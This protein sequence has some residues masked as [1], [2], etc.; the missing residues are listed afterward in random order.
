MW[1]TIDFGDRE[2]CRHQQR[3]AVGTPYGCGGTVL[4]LGDGLRFTGAPQRQQPHLRTGTCTYRINA[5]EGQG[6]IIGTDCGRGIAAVPEGQLLGPGVG[7]VEVDAPQVGTV[8]V[9]RLA[10]R[11]GG[12]IGVDGLHAVD[13]ERPVGRNGN[14]GDVANLEDVGPCNR[15]LAHGICQ[16]GKD[17]QAQKSDISPHDGDYT[18]SVGVGRQTGDRR[19]SPL[20]LLLR[21]DVDHF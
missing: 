4:Q 10:L 2:G 9:G 14:A 5:H 17:G 6:S 20:R 13:R 21:F 11:I 16:H 19:I 1:L 12:R 18:T 7:V 3:L 8:F 15:L